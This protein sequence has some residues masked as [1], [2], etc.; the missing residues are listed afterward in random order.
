MEDENRGRAHVTREGVRGVALTLFAERGYRATSMRDIAEALGMKAPSLYNHVRSKETLLVEIMDSAMDLALADLRAAIN[1]TEDV[2]EQLRH[3]TESLVLQFLFYPREVTVSNNE[4]RS[5]NE[6]H[7]S[8]IIAKRDEYG[9]GFRDLIERGCSRGLFHV[10][11]PR[12]ASYAILEMGNG[13]KVWFR[14]GDLYT[15]VEVA[16][17]YSDFALRI[18]GATGFAKCVQRVPAAEATDDGT[19]GS[20]SV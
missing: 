7:R 6:P 2:A 13:A 14:K 17:Q 15:E 9:R 1:S 12:L 10:E 5:L 3:A 4:I 20:R 16:R 11:S 18:V 19:R 8:R